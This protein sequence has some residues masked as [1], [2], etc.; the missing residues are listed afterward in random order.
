MC[1]HLNGP[2]RSHGAIWLNFQLIIIGGEGLKQTE[3][4]VLDG[5]WLTDGEFSCDTRIFNFLDNYANYPLLAITD[6]NFGTCHCEKDCTDVNVSTVVETTT[7][8][9]TTVT[10]TVTTHVTTAST[11]TLSTP[12]NETMIL[13]LN[14]AKGRLFAQG[15]NSRGE[16]VAVYKCL[17]GVAEQV[18]A[19]AGPKI[20]DQ[21]YFEILDVISLLES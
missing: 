18:Q 3:I 21:N 19:K 11:Q 13:A 17:Q 12:S 10:T 14:S 8:V 4:C 7:A 15:V 16:N 2:R 5:K 20:L 9:T 6:E 1:G